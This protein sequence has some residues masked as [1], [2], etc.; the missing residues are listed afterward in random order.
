MDTVTKETVTTNSD[1]NAAT[2]SVVN[3][4]SESNATVLQSVEY[5]I[6]FIFGALEILLAFRFI[7]MLT[8]ASATSTFV[9]FI[10]NLSGIFVYPFSGIFKT[11]VTQGNVAASVFE[12]ASLVAIIVFPVLAWGIVTLIHVLSRKQQPEDDI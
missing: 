8:G 6:Y 9:Q 11:A 2:S 5:L 10:Y 7:L 3:T 4:S 1:G 12:P